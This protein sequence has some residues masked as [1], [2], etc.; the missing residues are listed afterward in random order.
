MENIHPTSFSEM[1]L[2]PAL[3]EGIEG[4]GFSSPTPIQQQAIPVMLEGKDIIGSAQT[5]TGKTAAFVIPVINAIM[6]QPDKVGVKALIISP[7]RE[8]AM[9]IDQTIEGLGYFTG[10]SSCA[11]YGGNNK[12]EWD[13]QMAAIKKNVDIVVATPGRLLMHGSLGYLNFQSVQMLV[14]DEADKMLDMGFYQDIV[15]IVGELPEN[16]QTIMFSATMPPKIRELAR[17]VMRT[18][19]VEIN[20]QV[21]QPAEG[22]DQQVYVLYENQK[23]P[24]IVHLLKNAEIENMV[25]FSASKLGADEVH[26]SLTK[27]GLN[28]RVIHSD[29]SQ[30]E[31]LDVLRQFKNKEF[32]ILVAT[33]ILSRGIDIDNLSHVV[34]YN[35]PH[36]AEDY[37]HR[38]GRTARASKKGT[39]ITFVDPKDQHRFM[40]IEQFLKRE[41]PKIP[42]PDFLGEAPVYQPDRQRGRGGNSQHNGGQNRRPNTQNNHSQKPRHPHP[43]PRKEHPGKPQFQGKPQENRPNPPVQNPPLND[44]QGQNAAPPKPYKR[45]FKKRPKPKGDTPPPTV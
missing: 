25:I 40:R 28:T 17:K 11:I 20:L 32:P 18:K 27:A 42:L 44:H 23:I 9:Q 36:D 35:V 30:D 2:V 29:R 33:D 41:I 31:R 45:P 26:K 24:L 4:I 13:K 38:I 21:S 12:N 8:L 10:V 5:G 1:N 34:N 7:T 22:I 43:Q 16:R 3:L 37:V 6:Q 15:R 19:P 14:L 39:A